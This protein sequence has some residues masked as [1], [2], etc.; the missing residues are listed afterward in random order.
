M[1]TP[2][3]RAAGASRRHETRRASRTYGVMSHT[4]PASA[5]DRTTRTTPCRPPS[6]SG[7]IVIVTTAI[8]SQMSPHF[9]ARMPSDGCS[10]ASW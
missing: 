9:A 1:P 10:Q 4:T 8:T 7:R 6:T 3:R 2:V 5:I